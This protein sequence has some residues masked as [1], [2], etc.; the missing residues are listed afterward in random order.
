[1]TALPAIKSSGMPLIHQSGVPAL[2]KDGGCCGGCFANFS[3][4]SLVD[5]EVQFTD[6]SDPVPT[7]WAWDFGDGG[8][9]SE[10]NPTHVFPEYGWYEV[11]LDIVAGGESCSRVRDIFPPCPLLSDCCA[12]GIPPL[13]INLAVTGVNVIADGM[14]GACD[15]N[16]IFTL[17]WYAINVLGNELYRSEQFCVDDILDGWAARWEG[18]TCWHW[19]DRRFGLFMSLIMRREGFVD[20]LSSYRTVGTGHFE[21]CDDFDATVKFYRRPVTPVVTR[22]AVRMWV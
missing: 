9:S 21:G 3:A 20:N 18:G 22:G 14:Y 12:G 11:R 13:N 10:R 6:F 15:A 2:C 4:E 1:M 19:P 16:G 5:C 17:E 7:S 8:T